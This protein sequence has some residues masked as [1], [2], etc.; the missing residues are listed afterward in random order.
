M[1]KE[2]HEYKNGNDFYKASES[3][4]IWKVESPDVEGPYLF[5]FDQKTIFN[6]W[7]YYPD[8]LTPEQIEIFKKENPTMA[9]L[10]RS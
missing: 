1:P 3:E 6:F 7:T 5:S 4:Q 10:R 8:R 2:I 9:V